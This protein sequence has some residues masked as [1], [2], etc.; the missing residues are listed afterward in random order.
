MKIEEGKCSIREIIVPQKYQKLTVQNGQLMKKV[1]WV[2]GGKIPLKEIRELTSDEHEKFMKTKDDEYY[3]AM[4]DDDV[5]DMLQK[6]HE[7]DSKG[8]FT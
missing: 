2:E 4:K 6:M 7:Y 5:K 3:E 8:L 1:F